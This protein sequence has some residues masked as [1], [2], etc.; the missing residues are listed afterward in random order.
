LDRLIEGA[1]WAWQAE[2][3]I[4]VGSGDGAGGGI[5]LADILGEIPAVGVPGAV[6]LDSQR[7]GSNGFDGV[8]CDVPQGRVGSAGEVDAGNLQVASID[9][10]L[11]ER[12]TAVDCHL[13][14]RATAHGVIGTFHHCVA[15]RVGEAHGVS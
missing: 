9:V 5:E 10:A 8:P 13:L 6:D 11:V 1:T 15:F 12:Y 14:V 7:T 2:G 3:G 4:G